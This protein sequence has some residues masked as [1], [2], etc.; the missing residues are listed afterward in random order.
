MKKSI[1]I[2]PILLGLLLTIIIIDSI[3]A[4]VLNNNPIIGTETKCQKKVGFFV[5]TYHCSDKSVTKIKS[6]DNTCN[7]ESICGKKDEEE[8]PNQNQELFNCLENE[9]G[10]Y[11]VTEQDNLIDYDLTEI[12]NIDLE[13]I[14]YFKGVYA[15]THTDNTYLMVYPK[16]GTYDADIM[17]KF[18]EYFSSKFSEYQ[19]YESPLT[20]TIYIHTKDNN[21]D[22]SNITK[23]CIST[24]DN[25]DSKS[26]SK[27][28]LNKLE[29]TNKI[30][31]KSGE[32]IL[33]EITNKEAID[34]VVS[35]ISSS[36]QSGDAFLC[37][38]PAFDFVMYSDKSVINTF[39]VYHDGKRLFPK[40]TSKGCAYY[41]ITNDMDLRNIIEEETDYT[42]YSILDLSDICA[43]AL[44][45]I[46][47]FD[48][49]KYYLSCIKS[50][51]VLIK[52]L[53]TNKVMTLKYALENNYI[54]ADKVAS[55]YPNI[56]IKE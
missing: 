54:S 56:L 12:N 44:Q 20:P 18:T 10:G 45:Q 33:G 13:Q 3:Q 6:F 48:N 24:V 23:K 32:N 47:E 27:N 26:I 35:A 25:K 46:Y 17:N 1:M 42:F 34:K 28:T 15:S 30:T 36:K 2:I 21:L 5:E 40:G 37:D 16:N 39:S 43:E 31:I 41:T 50:D 4:L 14:D 8:I 55:D 7:N 38:A 49:H 19:M 52:F 22:I 29:L 53:L 51:K 9:L 11:L